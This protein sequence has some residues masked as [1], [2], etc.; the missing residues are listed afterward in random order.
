MKINL[1]NRPILRR[2]GDGLILCRSLPGDVEALAEYNSRIHSDFGFDNPDL[3]IGAWTRDL[4]NPNHPTFRSDDFTLVV[5][6]ASGRIVSAMNLISQVWA[7][8]G[9]P[10]KTGRPELVGTLPGFRNRG[11]IRAQFEEIHKRSARRG[12]LV[13][14]I[15][16][17]P[18]FYRLFGYEMGLE[19]GG[20][21]AG[22]EAQLPNLKE[23]E[24]EPFSFRPATVADIPFL[25][26]VYAHAGKRRLITCVRDEAIWRYE[27]LEMSPG[28]DN[29][30]EIRIIEQAET[31][32]PVGYLSHSWA[33]RDNGLFALHYELRKGI[34]WLEVTPSVARY[35]WRTGKTYQ[36]KDKPSE[37]ILFYGFWFGKEH[38]AYDIFRDRLPRMREP[39]AWY[40]RV[41]DLVKFLKVITPA[42]E[43]HLVESDIAGY[44]GEVT[45]GFYTSGVRLRIEKGKVTT[46]KPWMPEPSNRGKAVFPELT[47]LQLLFGYRSIDEIRYAR[48][49]CYYQDDETRVL[50]SIL[51]PKKSSSVM[52]L[53]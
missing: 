44:S 47:F 46:L 51:F 22:Y 15:T 13:Q 39:Y 45:I 30:Q 34:S 5:E 4:F 17:I 26:E 16:G 48:P 21:R 28:S 1:K 19:L 36:Q 33:I 3:R 8:E 27:L 23:G 49:D 53:N 50:L 25:M 43:L 7:Y 35:L 14:G 40:V 31:Q 2:L 41:P 29:R 20:G 42:L 52:F 9:I 37:N 10:F 6:A 24:P 11:L 32:K 38:P 18:Y 12:E